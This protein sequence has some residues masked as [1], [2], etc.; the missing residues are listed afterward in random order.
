MGGTRI[1]YGVVED[2]EVLAQDMMPAHSDQGLA[3]RLPVLADALLR[4]CAGSRIAPASCAGVGM[5][6]PSLIDVRSGRVLA[7]FGKY[8]DAMEV[9]IRA[10]SRETLRLPLAIEND[11]RMALIG[12]WRAGAGRGSE[13]VVMMTLGTGLG[14]SAVIE[15]RVLRGVHGQAGIL[16]GH[17]TVNYHGAACHCGNIGCAESEASTV[18]L[19]D[20]AR[21]RTDF[22]ASAL[23][24]EPVLDYA[25]IFRW[26]DAGD[27]CAMALRDHSLRVWSANAVNLVHAFDPELIVLGGGIMASGA[28]IVNA[29]QEY[30]NAHAM[31]PWGRVRVAASELG[32]QAALVACEWLVEE[33]RR[34]GWLD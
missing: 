8:T 12:E 4:L 9:D 30:V 3:S 10:W 18:V 33:H 14:V 17:L 1:K 31:T 7:E 29:V 32:D 26:A 6:F 19:E 5:S 23:S 15:G 22:A 27:A 16:G 13:N 21:R 11:A 2:G 34:E 25:A 28:V 24:N 20:L